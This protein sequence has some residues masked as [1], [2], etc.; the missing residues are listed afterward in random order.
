MLYMQTGA[1][2]SCFTGDKRKKKSFLYLFSEWETESQ[3]MWCETPVNK[4]WLVKR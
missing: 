4:R 3:I 2:D 1:E